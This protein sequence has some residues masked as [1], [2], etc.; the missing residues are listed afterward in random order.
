MTVNCRYAATALI[1]AYVSAS[2]LKWSLSCSSVNRVVFVLHAGCADH[3]KWKGDEDAALLC[4]LALARAEGVTVG[5]GCIVA[6]AGVG[7]TVTVVTGFA[8]DD[9]VCAAAVLVVLRVVV[10]VAFEL[11]AEVFDVHPAAMTAAT[12]T[13]A[14]MIPTPAFERSLRDAIPAPYAH[15][16]VA[17]RSCKLVSRP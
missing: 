16:G 10:V 14:M 13:H 11:G 4:G 5:V 9:V 7:L 1:K 3:P 15:T 8:G 17:T 2:L 12:H 6:A